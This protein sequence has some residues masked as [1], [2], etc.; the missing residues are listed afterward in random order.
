MYSFS[1]DARAAGT[2]EIAVKTEDIQPGNTYAAAK[3]DHNHR[4]V[5]RWGATEKHVCWA[6]TYQRLPHGGFTST[7]CTSTASFAKWA[8]ERVFG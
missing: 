7:R 4:T 8:G 6:P 1:A 3:G 5:V 2:G